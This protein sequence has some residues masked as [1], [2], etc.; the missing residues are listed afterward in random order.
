MVRSVRIALVSL[1]L[2]LLASSAGC[3]MGSFSVLL[4]DFDS[5]KIDG[6]RLWKLENGRWQPDVAIEFSGVRDH[7]GEEY[8]SYRFDIDTG[9]IKFEMV[10]PIEDV[11]AGVELSFVFIPIEEGDYKVSAYNDAG[12]SGLSAGTYSL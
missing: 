11:T 4:V 2:A 6:V 9:D 1:G 12:E 7:D 3:G 10:S 5:N 8:L